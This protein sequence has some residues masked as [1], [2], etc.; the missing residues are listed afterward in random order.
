MRVA[1][2]IVLSDDEVMKLGKLSKSR[3]AS[4]RLAE[5]SLIVLLVGKGMTHEEIGEE[6]GMTRQKAGRKMVQT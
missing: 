2:K 3:S 6:L 4:V 5:R 1:V